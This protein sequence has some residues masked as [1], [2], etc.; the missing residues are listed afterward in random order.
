MGTVVLGT[1]SCLPKRILT[2]VEIESIVDTS[3]EWI[4][5]RTGIAARRVGGKGEKTYQLA[6]KAAS[7]ALDAAGVQA[8]EIDLVL[9][10]TISSHMLMPSTACFVQ[11]EVGAKNAFAYDINAACSGF[12]YGFD[13]ADK[14]IQAD[15]AKKILVIGVETLSAKLNWKDRNTCILFGDGAGAAVVGHSESDRGFLRSKFGSDGSLWELLC[16]HA[17]RSLNPELEVEEYPGSHVIMEGRE[18][19][20]HAVRAMEDSVRVVLDRQ[21]IGLDSVDLVIPHQANIRI[22]NKLAE[23]LKIPRE[24]LFI[25]VSKYGNTSAAS[26]P[27]ALDEANSQGLI[28]AGDTV[29][30]CAF[31]GGF[32]WGAVLIKW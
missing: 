28:S 24:K 23:R 10:G 11:N 1:G 22:L 12:L 7:R 30:F 16:M 3:D 19:F 2:N 4:Q 18:V 27:I 20:K 21:G 6:A 8:E 13:L 31:G 5:N 14:Y 26:I 17:P 15:N 25:N 29:L 9:V 32:T